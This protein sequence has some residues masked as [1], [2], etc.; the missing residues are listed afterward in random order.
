LPE[1][2]DGTAKTVKERVEAWFMDALSCAPC[3]L[4]LRRLDFLEKLSGS[5]Q[6][7]HAG[8]S[9]ATAEKVGS[10]Y[11]QAMIVVMECLRGLKAETLLFGSLP[12][13]VIGTLV[14]DGQLPGDCAEFFTQELVIQVT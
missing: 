8:M 4:L 6:D 1:L 13:I 7:I 9:Y 3:L 10:T 2:L 5:T 14:G 12:V 11:P